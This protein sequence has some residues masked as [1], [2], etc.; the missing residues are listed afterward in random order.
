[1]KKVM[2]L[3][4]VLLAAVALAASAMAGTGGWANGVVT[5]GT[6][7]ATPKPPATYGLSSNVWIDYATANSNQD[8]VVTSCHMS[9]NRVFGTTNQTTLIFYGTK[10]TGETAPSAPTAPA[11]GATT[12]GSGWT[13]L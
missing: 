11:A 6:G 12:F 1:M 4:I 9:G 3:S 13:A 5:L 10:N 7:G 2:I 8:Y